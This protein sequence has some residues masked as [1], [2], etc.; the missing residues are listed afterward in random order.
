M[1]AQTVVDEKPFAEAEEKFTELVA[2]LRTEESRRMR[3][4]ELESLIT[5]EG[6]EIHR[7]LL[8]AHLDLRASNERVVVSVR[9]AD[10]VERTHHRRRARPLLTVFG[11][12]TAMRMAY[13]ARGHRSLAPLDAL[14]NLPEELYARAEAARSRRGGP[15]IVRRDGGG[16]R[17]QHGHEGA[18]APGGGAGQ[19]GGTGL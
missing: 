1:E 8:Q 7:R 2:R 12:V 17:A 16:H 10:E 15:W 4:S 19:A 13:G 5:S 14:L 3:H 11:L 6:R 9:G 18:Q